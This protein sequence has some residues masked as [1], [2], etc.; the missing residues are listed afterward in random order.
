MS[1]FWCQKS[2][3]PPELTDRFRARFGNQV[4]VYHSALSEGERY[5][6]WRQM[7]CSHP[8]VVIGTRS[9]VFAPLP[10]LGLII[11]DEEHD[12]SFKQDS[13]APCYHARTIAQWRAALSHCPLI[14]GSATPCLETWISTQAV[15]QNYGETQG[16]SLPPYY[17]ALPERIYARPLPPVEIIDMR[18][19]LHQGNH[20]IFSRALQSALRDLSTKQQQGILF[21]HRRGH[22]TFVSCRSCG[23]VLDCPNCD[24]SLSYHWTHE[25]AQPLL[26]CHYC[27]F[28]QRHPPRM[29]QL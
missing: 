23:N 8:Q 19:E 2:A 25:Q 16:G 18:E 3:S 21:I 14:L 20:S 5:D 17:L 6:T 11:L 12:T 7:L 26:R 10:R 28:S 22:S 13:P 4:C 1:W 15:T 27:N 29:P 24:V 9:A